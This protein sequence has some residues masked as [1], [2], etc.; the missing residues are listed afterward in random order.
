ML[1]FNWLHLEFFTEALLEF[2]GKFFA[3][4]W[5]RNG[6]QTL[7]AL[8]ERLT[9][10]LRHAVLGDNIIDI[11][12]AGGN[13]TAGGNGCNNLRCRLVLGGRVQRN[14][15]TAALGQ[16]CAAHKVHLTAD[17]GNLAQADCLG[18]DL[19]LQIDLDAGV[20]GNHVVV[21]RDNGRIVADIHWKH[22]NNR[23]IVHEIV[24]FSRAHQE[25]DA[26]LADVALLAL[27][28]NVAVF[29]Q[30]QH[31]V[32]DHLSV[33]AEVVLVAE[34]R[35]DRIRHRTDAELQA[36]TVAHEFGNVLA[37][38]AVLLT[39]PGRLGL[40]QRLPRAQV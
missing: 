33:Q 39:D 14:D 15:G 35:A 2:L 28:V 19:P 17:A 13:R 37:D 24:Q 25:G 8:A 27:A 7:C 22:V 4:F 20:N 3:E 5:M 36:V 30:R 38:G 34:E 21:L 23:V 10:K 29:K 12:A 26:H 40:G 32:R 31:A 1:H 11:A 9:A 6:N 16:V 18:T